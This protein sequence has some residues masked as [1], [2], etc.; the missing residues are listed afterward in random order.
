MTKKEKMEMLL[1]KVAE[2]Q[3]A[4][5]VAGMRDTAFVFR[6]TRKRRS[7]PSQT[8]SRTKSLMQRRAVAATPANALATALALIKKF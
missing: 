6:R 7:K 8:K 3:K 4:D 5:F 2:D 1:S